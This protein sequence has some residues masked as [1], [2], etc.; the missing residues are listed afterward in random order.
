MLGTK[1]P[2]LGASHPQEPASGAGHQKAHTKP[3]LCQQD[4]QP[5]AQGAA[6]IGTKGHSSQSVIPDFT[7]AEQALSRLPGVYSG[8]DSCSHAAQCPGSPSRPER[9]LSPRAEL[10][11]GMGASSGAE[12]LCFPTPGHGSVHRHQ[13]EDV[14]LGLCEQKATAPLPPELPAQ[15]ERTP[16]GTGEPAMKLSL[17]R[18]AKDIRGSMKSLVTTITGAAPDKRRQGGAGPCIQPGCSAAFVGRNACGAG[19]RTG[20]CGSLAGEASI[21][22]QLQCERSPC[23]GPAVWHFPVVP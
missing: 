1:K 23:V 15:R 10:P 3:R 22:H 18:E 11:S 14:N 13:T 17:T 12:D 6:V 8:I 21:P 7:Q 9:L 19:V 5:R 16:H 2:D 20:R 4:S